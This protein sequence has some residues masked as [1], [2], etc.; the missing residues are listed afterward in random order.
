MKKVLLLFALLWGCQHGEV[1]L[2][3][4]D[5][6]FAALYADLLLLHADYERVIGSGGTFSKLDSLQH[7]FSF[8]RVSS[9]QFNTQLIRYKEEPDRWLKVQDRALSMLNQRRE[10]IVQQIRSREEPL[11]AQNRK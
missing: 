2:D 7:I 10:P 3:D 5:E 4:D 6:R 9:E 11:N 1:R 8:H